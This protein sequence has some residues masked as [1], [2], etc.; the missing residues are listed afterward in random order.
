MRDRP[1]Q[2]GR[3]VHARHVP[4]PGREAYVDYGQ[5][6]YVVGED[7]ARAQRST[8]SSRKPAAGTIPFRGRRKLA[9]ACRTRTPRPPRTTSVPVPS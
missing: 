3:R 1:E 4:Q 8:P 7:V 9:F 6:A 2:P 5:E